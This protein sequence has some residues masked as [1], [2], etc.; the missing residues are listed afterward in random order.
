MGLEKQPLAKKYAIKD[1]RRL[2]TNGIER[3][4]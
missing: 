3:K 1:T 2:K 4:A